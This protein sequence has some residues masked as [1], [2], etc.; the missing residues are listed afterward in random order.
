[1]CSQQMWEISH[2]VFW[3]VLVKWVHTYTFTYIWKTIL[4]FFFFFEKFQIGTAIAPFIVYLKNVTNMKGLPPAIF[5]SLMIFGSIFLFFTPETKDITLAQTVDELKHSG[6]TSIYGQFKNKMKKT[7]SSRNWIY[8]YY[9]HTFVIYI[10]VIKIFLFIQFNF[11]LFHN[12]LFNFLL[13]FMGFLVKKF[14]N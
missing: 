9:L 12:N 2:F 3:T 11:F 8:Y 10:V 6:N 13:S 14:L 4:K 5:G 7:E 1:M